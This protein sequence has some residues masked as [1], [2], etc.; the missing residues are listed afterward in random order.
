VS[1]ALLQQG[2]GFSPK[3]LRAMLLGVDKRR[4]GQQDG[5][6]DDE[7]DDG[8]GGYGAVPRAHARSDAGDGGCFCFVPPASPRFDFPTLHSSRCCLLPAVADLVSPFRIIR[9]LLDGLLHWHCLE[10]DRA[11]LI[12]W[13]VPM[14]GTVS[15]LIVHHDFFS[16]PYTHI[17]VIASVPF[18]PKLNILNWS[19][20]E[21][22]WH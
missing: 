19:L 18:F 21:D 2:G 16:S 11:I 12:S 4:K 5:G 17:P 13:T 9:G 8:D 6:A 15:V 14:W 22:G 1:L 3:R 7:E 10:L 20:G